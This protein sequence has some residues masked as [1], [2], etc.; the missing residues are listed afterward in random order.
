M[1]L[2][3]VVACQDHTCLACTIR[4]AYACRV[5]VVIYTLGDQYD[6]MEPASDA[7]HLS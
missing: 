6:D 2:S 5:A 7:A 1:G 4:A 3:A